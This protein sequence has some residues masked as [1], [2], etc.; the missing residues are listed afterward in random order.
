MINQIT[1]NLSFQNDFSL[2][3]F[4]VSKCNINA[5][6][7]IEKWPSEKIKNNI[8]CIFGPNG[9]GKTHLAKIWA[10]KNNASYIT[11]V[12]EDIFEN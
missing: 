9:C 8:L 7:L 1:L 4:I 3:S 10:I 6:N 12:N 11:T 2:E 5:K